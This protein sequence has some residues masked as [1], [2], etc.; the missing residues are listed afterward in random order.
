MVHEHVHRRVDEQDPVAA[1]DRWNGLVRGTTPQAP[2]GRS[3]VPGADR[4]TQQIAARLT[5]ACQC[6]SNRRSTSA[7]SAVRVDWGVA[8]V[9]S[10]DHTKSSSGAS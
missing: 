10:I 4:G 6:T 8:A 9:A 1:G 7:R 3:Q 5:R 2:I